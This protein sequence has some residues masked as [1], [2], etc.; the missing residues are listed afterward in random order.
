[1]Y[2]LIALDMDGTLF[3][4]DKKISD[5][6]KRAISR[7][8]ELGVKIV[9]ASGRPL[10]GLHKPLAELN[11]I[12]DDEYVLCYNG[13][14][15]VTA[16][17]GKILSQCTLTG[18]DCKKLFKLSEE[19]KVHC[20]AF[21]AKQGL[22]TNEISHYTAYEAEMNEMQCHIINPY[23]DIADD[24]I[25]T[26]LMFIDPPEILKKAVD[27]IPEWVYTD[28]NAFSS[29]PFF[30]EITN[31]AVDK[32][33]GLKQLAESLNITQE[34]VIACGDENNDYSMI[35]YAGLGVAMGNA[36]D[37]IKAVSDY[38]TDTNDNDGVAKVIEKFILK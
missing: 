15:A 27:K 12:S 35:K 19:L 14:L 9:L 23:T 28:Y 1:M 26:K 31:K 6:T 29:T 38:I 37:K 32:G 10:D 18:K 36:I 8:R 20:H 21:S 7:A 13:A 30:F 5:R 33:T 3:T 16:K 11:L 2:K 4:S 24:E 17:T 34:E 22:I 25:I